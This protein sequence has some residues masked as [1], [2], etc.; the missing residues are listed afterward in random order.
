LGSADRA[1][2]DG[3]RGSVE[4]RLPALLAPHG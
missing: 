1:P 4:Y 3:Q 2:Y